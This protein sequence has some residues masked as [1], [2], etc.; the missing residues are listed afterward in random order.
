[1]P[2]M[3]QEVWRVVLPFNLSRSKHYLKSTLSVEKEQAK[4]LFSWMSVDINWENDN[5]FL[6]FACGARQYASAQGK[7]ISY[8]DGT[9]LV[10]LGFGPNFLE[11]MFS[12]FF[13]LAAILFF[14]YPHP[15]ID[16]FTNLFGGVILIV[17]AY[18]QLVLGSYMIK[19]EAKKVFSLT[20]VIDLMMPLSEDEMWLYE[21]LRPLHWVKGNS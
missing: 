16:I 15:N 11:Q 19:K 1:M 18:L 3:P 9:T 8:K 17:C 10:T 14:A 2:W 6:L 13:I 21:R 12:Y 7:M 4:T 5:H 20:N